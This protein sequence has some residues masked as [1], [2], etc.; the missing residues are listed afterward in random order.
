MP[1]GQNGHLEIPR[2]LLGLWNLNY[3]YATVTGCPQ[4]T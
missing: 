3:R 2:V 4:R 1:Q